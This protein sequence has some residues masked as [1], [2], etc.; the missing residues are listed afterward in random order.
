MA[1]ILAKEGLSVLALE[2]KVHPRVKPC[3]GCISQRIDRIFDL[4][5]LGVV[6]SKIRGATFTYRGRDAI[7]EY[8]DHTVAYM[9]RREE[10]DLKL[11]RSAQR[12]G[13]DIRQN[14]PVT[15][16][17]RNNGRFSIHSRAG[18]FSAN[19]VVGADGVLSVVRRSLIPEER[20]W[21]YLTLVRRIPDDA[22]ARAMEDRVRIDLG[23][24]SFGYGWVFP[25][26]DTLSAGL[27]VLRSRKLG[28][29]HH[30]TEFLGSM[31]LNRLVTSPSLS[32]HTHLIKCFVGRKQSVALPG[33]LLVG[34][35]AGLT[36]PLTGEGIYFAV[37]SAQCAGEA[38][39]NHFRNE[40]EALAGYQKRID[41]E[42]FSEFRHAAWMTRMIYR[43][44]RYFFSGIRRH[45]EFIQS[46]FRLLRG[47]ITYGRACSHL[48]NRF[49]RSVW[50]WLN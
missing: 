25:H 48:K 50:P 37:H 2:K 26:T 17:L 30:F 40:P 15:G 19:L 41:Q 1:K 47:E 27:A 7:T 20:S 38:I 36:D 9:I 43:F 3:G 29:K 18:T 13:A 31:N 45:P 44:P 11:V 8:C 6:E 32:T 16:V 33:V 5:T 35:A 49:L 14:A 22:A 28:F 42:I 34:D 21:E 46:F 24:V 10:F 23:W 4:H 39:L 12:S